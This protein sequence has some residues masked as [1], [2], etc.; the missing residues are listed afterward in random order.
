MAPQK[1]SLH[2]TER[3]T[4]QVQQA[5]AAYR[6]LMATLDVRRLQFVAEAG[7]NLAMTRW[8][9]RAPRGTRVIG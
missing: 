2:A 4:A 1:K 7:V 9:G 3:D 5:R 8:Y 6:Q